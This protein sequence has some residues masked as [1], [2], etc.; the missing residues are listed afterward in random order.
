MHHQELGFLFL[1]SFQLDCVGCQLEEQSTGQGEQRADWRVQM[2]SLGM[3]SEPAVQPVASIPRWGRSVNISTRKLRLCVLCL[4]AVWDATRTSLFAR[5]LYTHT[6]YRMTFKGAVLFRCWRMTSLIRVL[7]QATS[8]PLRYRRV[9][10]ALEP[11]ACRSS[12][13]KL[14]FFLPL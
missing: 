10:Y 11:E 2:P 3:I 9:N 14:R 1:S 7:G 4:S 12:G 6:S 5:S 8:H 13:R